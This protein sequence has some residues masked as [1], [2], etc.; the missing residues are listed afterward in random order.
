MKTTLLVMT[1]NEI[2]GMRQIMPAI[3]RAW[4]DQIIIVDGGS[5]DGTVEWAREQGYEVYCQQRKGIRHGYF[6]VLPQ[7]KGELIILFSPDGNCLAEIIPELKQKIIDGYDMVIGSR[8]L[9]HA[10]S[11]DDDLFTG[12]GNWLF[13]RT[14]NLLYGGR[15]TDVMVIFRAFRRRLI[16]DL[17]LLDEEA[18]APCERL[19]RTV[20]SWELLM[21]VRA[22]KAGKRV[23]EVP[24]SEPRR[25]GGVRKL[26]VI[27]WGA[28]Y[29]LQFLREIY[30]WRPSRQSLTQ[31]AREHGQRWISAAQH[32]TGLA[33]VVARTSGPRQTAA[34]APRT[35][36][37]V[38][39][40]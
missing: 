17:D 32:G 1:L 29:Y 2:D 13:T 20:I 22:M 7:V 27:R 11:E 36:I 3:D 40:N 14:V 12:F 25:V 15:Y 6:E 18:Y 37:V 23:T 16:D 21:S 33:L 5:T 34:P 38:A 8:Y 9:G 30:Y 35:R 24:A 19:F 28:A 4:C 39:R 31:H 10:I 26:Q